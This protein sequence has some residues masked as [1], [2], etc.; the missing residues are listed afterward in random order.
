MVVESAVIGVD[1]GGTKI[2]SAACDRIGQLLSENSRTTN[3]HEAPE[4]VIG[5]IADSINQ[6]I[7]ES[8][9][10]ISAVGIAVPGPVNVERGIALNAVNLGW[11]NVPLRDLLR[12]HLIDPS[13]PVFLQNDV[14]GLALGEL[15]FGAAR[16]TTDF[17]Y[18][19]LGTGLGGGAVVNGQVINGVTGSAMEVGHIVIVPEGRPCTCGQ[20][21]CV[22]QYVSG[23]GL[24]A[25]AIEHGIQPEN[26]ETVNTHYLIA[27]AKAGDERALTLMREAADAL[28]IAMAMCAMVLNP[29]M[30]VIGGG[31]GL[32]CY[33]LIVPQAEQVFR[34]RLIADIGQTV[35]VVPSQVSSSA[36]GSAALA[37]QSLENEY[38]RRLS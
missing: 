22:E 27:R 20:R 32:A 21:G 4:K 37:W 10:S 29:S 11:K 25:G 33:D 13:L 30:I 24:I 16:D 2:L 31:L 26:G 15:V 5:R 12:P 17:V 3:A 18:L 34:N 1:V 36:L 6:V 28:G 9:Q 7:A 14:N 19:A 23:H 8:R 35:R 38:L